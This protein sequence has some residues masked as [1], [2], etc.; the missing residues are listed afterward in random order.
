M[1]ES[2]PNESSC[3]G[4]EQDNSEPG[5]IIVGQAHAP[6]DRVGHDYRDG[7][8]RVLTDSL[9]WMRLMASAIRGAEVSTVNFE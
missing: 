3:G 6:R 8:K 4:C 1:K 5:R 9:R 2:K 7:R